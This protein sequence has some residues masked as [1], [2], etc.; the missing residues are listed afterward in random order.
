MLI[1]DPE[2]SEREIR[3]LHAQG[4]LNS[5]FRQELEA[6]VAGQ[7]PGPWEPGFVETMLWAILRVVF[8]PL[9]MPEYLAKLYNDRISSVIAAPTTMP[10]VLD[11]L[12]AQNLLTQEFAE[13]LLHRLN[14]ECGTF[15]GADMWRECYG[16]LPEGLQDTLDRR[17][18]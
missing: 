13:L 17:F 18:G 9:P 6:C 16:R 8:I 1:V 5:A 12:Q 10:A 3:R 15:I 14:T 11:E 4:A 7:E 2:E